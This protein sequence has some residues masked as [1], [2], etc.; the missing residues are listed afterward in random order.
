MTLTQR[1]T[2]SRP[3]DASD[4]KLD[5]ANLEN[6]SVAALRLRWQ[7]KFALDA[8]PI[9]SPDTLRRLLAFELQAAV[10]GGNSAATS[11]KLQE[12]A[13][14]L[15]RDGTYEPQIRS[16]RAGAVLTRVWK[17][18]LHKVTVVENG[19]DYRG[20]LHKSLSVIA[21]HITGTRWSGPR[22]FGLEKRS[23]R[24]RRGQS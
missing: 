24:S 18:A 23:A 10:F 19:F 12:I 14:A 22:F 3:P 1:H 11:R 16:L 17:G 4:L 6:L 8:P 9:R 13:K 15:A 20:H 2:R 7:S 21:R 5:I